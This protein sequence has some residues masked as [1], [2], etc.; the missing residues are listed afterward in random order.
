MDAVAVDGGVRAPVEQTEDAEEQENNSGDKGALGVLARAMHE[1]KSAY[2]GH[3]EQDA[4][5]SAVATLFVSSAKGDSGHPFRLAH[6]ADR[7][8]VQAHLHIGGH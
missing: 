4:H 6:G 2:T 5:V 7:T 1:R 8:S 3:K